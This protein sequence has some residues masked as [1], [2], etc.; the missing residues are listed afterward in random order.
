MGA[1]NPV[2][3]PHGGGAGWTTKDRPPVEEKEKTYNRTDGSPVTEGRDGVGRDLNKSGVQ[4]RS[5]ERDG[6]YKKGGTDTR[7]IIRNP[8]SRLKRDN[9]LINEGMI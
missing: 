7:E 6:P 8:G 4:K 1:T 9:Q 3:V 2:R 5:H